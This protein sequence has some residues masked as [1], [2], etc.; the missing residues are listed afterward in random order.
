MNLRAKLLLT[1]EDGIRL[2]HDHRTALLNRMFDELCRK[3]GSLFAEQVS[4][5]R[6]LFILA[7]QQVVDSFIFVLLMAG[8]T[9][10]ARGSGFASRHR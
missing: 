7:L 4:H 2:I 6:G 8:K 5:P 10:K 9:T 1:Q 3:P